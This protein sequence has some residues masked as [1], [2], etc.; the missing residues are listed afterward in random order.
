MQWANT[1]NAGFS[2]AKPENLYLPVDSAPD[3]PTVH[4]QENDP[5]SLLQRV[6]NLVAIRKA[7]PA[8]QASADFQILFAHPGMYPL[9]YLRTDSRDT[10]IIAVNPSSQ[11]VDTELTSLSPLLPQTVYGLDGVFRIQNNRWII[12]L[13]PISGG[14]YSVPKS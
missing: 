2:T 7:H 11:T 10:F 6:R 13:P 5:N 1:A 12:T 9:I 8:L 3:R 14:I 4:Q